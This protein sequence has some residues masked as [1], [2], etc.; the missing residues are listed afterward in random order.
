[1]EV[2]EEVGSH[3]TGEAPPLPRLPHPGDH[4]RWPRLWVW[5]L[6]FLALFLP[7]YFFVLPGG[8]FW[9]NAIYA[10]FGMSAA[11]AIAIGPALNGSDNPWP[12]WLFA[13]GTFLFS[14]GDIAFDVYAAGGNTPIPSVAD[15]LYL[16]AYPILAVGM[17]LMV[18]SRFPGR[19]LV[20][21]VDGVIVA[22]GTFVVI[23]VL[24]MEP[25]YRNRSL[26]F[27]AKVIPIAY[28]SM[29][30]L[31]LAVVI[32]VVIKVGDNNPSFTM[33]VASV[34][35]LMV[36]DFVYAV[37]QLNGWYHSGDAVDLGYMIS[38]GLWGASALH[39]SMRRATHPMPTR[40]RAGR[41]EIALL[42]LAALAAPAALITLDVMHKRHN[43]VLLASVAMIVFALVL[44]R[45]AGMTQ[46]LAASHRRLE[47]QRSMTEWAAALLAT[48]ETEEVYEAA[49]EAAIVLAGGGDAR[50]TLMVRSSTGIP[51]VVATRSTNHDASPQEHRFRQSESYFDELE[52][53]SR[54]D[55]WASGD[56][57]GD[58]A[59]V[60][61]QTPASTGHMAMRFSGPILVEGELAGLLFVRATVKRVD[62]ARSA[63]DLLCS[64][65][66]RA[67]QA[68]E[69]SKEKGRSQAE[70]FF[71][72][73]VKGSS[74]ALTL[75]ETDG[76]LRY[77]SPSATEIFGRSPEMLTGALLGDIAHPDDVDQIVSAIQEIVDEGL[78][79][80]GR[81]EFR[82]RHPDGQWR[83]LG[84]TATNLLSDPDVKA[85]VLSSTDI[86]PRKSLERQ[87][88]ELS[89]VDPV[90]GLPNRR[91]LV[92]RLEQELARVSRVNEM[93]GVLSIDL[94]HFSRIN[95]EKGRAA[96]DTFLASA[97]RNVTSALRPYD[98]LTRI[99]KDQFVAV[100]PAIKDVDDIFGLAI[101]AVRA[102]REPVNIGEERVTCTASVGASIGPDHG[103]TADELIG[104]AHEAM[105]QAKAA[106][107]DTYA[108]YAGTTVVS[109][110]AP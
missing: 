17:I 108:I 49:A 92:D 37:G 4:P 28:P 1:M 41:I 89:L 63:L 81:L 19:D 34:F 56:L 55:A 94:D 84:S 30:L 103:R 10:L 45:L 9:D 16:A 104:C 85:I 105:R 72:S 3:S 12:W 110:E 76:L 97:A 29:D 53:R 39:P 13:A 62:E 60:L 95:Q 75:M 21:A 48:A 58:I 109:G 70:R 11:A 31:L 15:Y 93:M 26:G 78:G 23:W 83:D 68:A 106:G 80:T 20:S 69:A 66:G 32:R 87:L 40:P 86:T 88:S 18:R 91:L 14:G 99:G 61:H 2:V 46:Q 50:A 71:R 98:T 54:W 73:V 33:L 43:V 5:F 102:L 36:T 6:I 67:I 74:D 25:Y 100:L 90:T 27:G 64:L 38:Y 35:T 42:S 51:S 77:M 7:V 24:I 79:A 82:V 47:Q 96:G 57:V 101:R 22:L 44:V 52:L 107:R 59:P 8:L 65:L